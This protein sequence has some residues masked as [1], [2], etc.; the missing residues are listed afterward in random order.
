MQDLVKTLERQ[1]GPDT[2]ELGMRFGIHSGPVTAGVLR[3]ER[4]RFQLFGDTVNT[5]ARMESTGETNR[6]HISKETAELLT[7]AGKAHWVHPRAEMVIAKGKGALQTYWLQLKTEEAGESSHD[8]EYTR[9]TTGRL[10]G[11]RINVDAAVPR[12]SPK[13]S[14]L[15]DWNTDVLSKLLKDILSRREAAGVKPDPPFQIHQLEIKSLQRDHLVLD[16]VAE[17]ITLPTF[18]PLAAEKEVDVV[19]LDDKVV[20]QLHDF[21]QTISVLYRDNPFHNFEHV[22]HVTMSVT[23]LLSRIVAP[24]LNVDEAQEKTL[25]DHTYGITSDPLTQ[26]AVVFSAL[27][28]DVDHQGVPNS[29]LVK[30]NASIA[31]VYKNKSV[32]EQ[33]SGMSC[34]STTCLFAPTCRSLTS[35]SLATFSRYRVG[36][37]HGGRI[38]RFATCH[39]H[40]EGRV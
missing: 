14:R 20:Q 32:A 13:Q 21:I 28:H 23:K 33:N 15:I 5:T 2:A 29:Q 31:S 6:I 26:F 27:I 30:E 24:D 39:L 36:P 3:G 38:H 11:L 7:A 8:E 17:I 34:D 40:N 12:I 25:H 16:E 18:D 9:D 22:S 37:A 10:N 19:T 4:A 35:L 1:L